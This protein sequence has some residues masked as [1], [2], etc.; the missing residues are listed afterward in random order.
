M[1]SNKY[2]DKVKSC[3]ADSTICSISADLQL[4]VKQCRKEL[5]A[6]SSK[7]ELDTLLK[8]ISCKIRTVQ[9][10]AQHMEKR[11]KKYRSSIE[12]LGFVRK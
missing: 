12:S 5:A 4:L 1:S 9:N 10:K 3:D 8:V 2:L 6:D 7:N 11:L